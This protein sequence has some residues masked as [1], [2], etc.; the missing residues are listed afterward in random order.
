M[1]QYSGQVTVASAAA[2]QLPNIATTVV[3]I[4][5]HPDNTQEIFVGNDG[6]DTISVATGF[7]IAPSGEIIRMRLDGNLNELYAIAEV[8]SEK[9]C[10]FLSID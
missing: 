1:A 10:W 5:G 2:T 7:P 8:D 3:Y 6:N 4:T 9:L